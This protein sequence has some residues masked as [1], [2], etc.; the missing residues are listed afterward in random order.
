ME[1]SKHAE[2]RSQQRSI[3]KDYIEMIMEYGTPTKKPGN[4]FEYKLHRKNRDRVIS[5][6]KHLIT[7][8][9]KCTKKAVLVDADNVCD[10]ITVYNLT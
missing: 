5:H 4:A 9:D 2:I 8:V 10:V 7:L 6:L 3:P 1:L